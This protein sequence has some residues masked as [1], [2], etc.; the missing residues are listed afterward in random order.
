LDLLNALIV[1][2]TGMWYILFA[3]PGVN[4][5]GYAPGIW[6]TLRLVETMRNR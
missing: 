2:L 4:L 1:M 6:G 3:G 5:V